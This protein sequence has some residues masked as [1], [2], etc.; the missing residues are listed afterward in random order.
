M[1]KIAILAALAL[2][3]AGCA[4]INAARDWLI[5]PK[6]QVAAQVVGA[7]LKVFICGLSQGAQIALAVEQA[8]Q[9][10]GQTVTGMILVGSTGVCGALGGVTQGTAITKAGDVVVTAAPASPVVQ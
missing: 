10:K 9:T 4:E 3:L 6:T 2:P 1:K 7:G 5:D 8:G